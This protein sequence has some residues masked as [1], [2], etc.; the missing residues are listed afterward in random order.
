MFFDF[1]KRKK[2]LDCDCMKHSIHFFYD[3][4]RACCI[5][6]PGPVFYENYQGGNVDWDFV[7][8]K[9]KALVKQINSPFSEKEYPSC[10][11]G[12]CEK[13][14]KF[15]S[16][17]VPKFENKI[18]TM[19]FHNHMSCNAKCT[20]CTYGY[21]ERGYKYRVLPLVKSLID[22]EILSRNAHIYMSG[23][24]ITISTEF[25][26]L[27]SVLLH[28]IYSKVEILTSGIKYCK[29]IEEAFIHDKCKLVISLDSANSE[30]YKKIKQVDCF[31]KVV[32]N[33]KDYIKASENAKSN[34]TMKYIIVDGVNDNNEEI[35]NFIKLVS[36][37]GIK[38]I[39]L[40]FD[41]EKYKYTRN[42]KVPDYYFDLYK[43]FNEVSKQCGLNV[44]KCDQ[45]EAILDKSH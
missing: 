1:L 32:Q 36:E 17:K 20:Y 26:G 12:C 4:I 38:E 11:E 42:I 43:N 10:C 27:L 5:N 19:Y 25:E 2:Y 9:R 31:D 16:K 3:E 7:Y 41:Y 21:I 34:I 8:R 24:E 30:T 13:D 28:Y 18:D 29:S 14:S 44:Q 40:D 37:L 15:S 35:T 45:I 33:I 6:I 22:K 23:G 39:R